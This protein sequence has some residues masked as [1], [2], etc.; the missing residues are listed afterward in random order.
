[1]SNLIP[2]PQFD[3][4][5]YTFNFRLKH[6]VEQ[7]IAEIIGYG[8]STLVSLRL[9]VD[10]E[11]G[12]AFSM[13]SAKYVMGEQLSGYYQNERLFTEVYNT[14]TLEL[15]N[16]LE[17]PAGLEL[18]DFVS[19]SEGIVDCTPVAYQKGFMLVIR[20][21]W[22]ENKAG[23]FFN[24]NDSIFTYQEFNQ[25]FPQGEPACLTPSLP[26]SDFN[27]LAF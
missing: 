7:E 4:K 15:Y 6:I 3:T 8:L 22:G 23:T 19:G 12:D 20:E 9:N 11:F 5:V 14:C 13:D 24:L 1:M 27:D 26:S 2:Y 21:G 25:M 10:G 17:T 18:Q 16:L